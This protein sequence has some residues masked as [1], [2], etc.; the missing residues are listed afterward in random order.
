MNDITKNLGNADVLNV[1]SQS[2]KVLFNCFLVA[3]IIV[4][5]F[6]ITSKNYETIHDSSDLSTQKL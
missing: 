4:G 3:R 6:V 1:I 2:E 5:V